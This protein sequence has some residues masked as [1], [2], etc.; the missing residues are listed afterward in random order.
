MKTLLALAAILLGAVPVAAQSRAKLE[1]A[2][3]IEIAFEVG[4]KGQVVLTKGEEKR[5][6]AEALAP[7]KVFALMD[8]VQKRHK[9]GGFPPEDKVPK[10]WKGDSAGFALLP[11][12]I[13]SIDEMN[14]TAYDAA[15]N[16]VFNFGA[17]PVDQDK[18]AVLHF[19]TD[20]KD[21]KSKVLWPR[22][23]LPL[24]E[25]TRWLRAVARFLPEDT[26][27]PALDRRRRL[28]VGKVK[29]GEAIAKLGVAVAAD[30]PLLKIEVTAEFFRPTKARDIIDAL[31]R[32]RP[33]LRWKEIDGGIEISVVK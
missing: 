13:F 20:E 15:G 23:T 17:A 29:L 4:E 19:A 3:K 5:A 32:Q 25:W 21:K 16:F 31:C 8:D 10:G 24:E 22:A 26:K 14:V 11:F 9:A 28:D 12:G 1:K 33:G 30:D 6:L 18:Q 7:L 2:A 27:G